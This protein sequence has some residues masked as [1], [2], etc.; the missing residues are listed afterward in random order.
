LG[1]QILAIYFLVIM[2]NTPQDSAIQ[3][4]DQLYKRHHAKLSDILKDAN[5]PLLVCGDIEQQ[6]YFFNKDIKNKVIKTIIH[7][8]RPNTLRLS[9]N[10]TKG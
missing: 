9:Q 5:I 8:N 4:V 3:A 2:K 10:N 6:F 1:L 7:Q